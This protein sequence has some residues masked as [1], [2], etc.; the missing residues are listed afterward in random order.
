[1]SVIQ[2][3]EINKYRATDIANGKSKIMNRKGNLALRRVDGTA[4]TT[5]T[6]KSA[7]VAA[8]AEAAKYYC[9]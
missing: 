1:L 5:G 2:L 4:I 8:A 6:V 3:V 7:A 9:H